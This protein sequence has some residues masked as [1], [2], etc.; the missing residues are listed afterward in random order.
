M[1]LMPARRFTKRLTELRLRLKFTYLL[2]KGRYLRHQSR[3]LRFKV[4]VLRSQLVDPFPKSLF[5]RRRKWLLDPA[6]AV[7]RWFLSVRFLL[8]PEKV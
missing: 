3:V 8:L 1:L 5:I 6:L 7:H 4:R 2:M